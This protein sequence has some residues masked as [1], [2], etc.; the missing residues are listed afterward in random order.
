[1]TGEI[2]IQGHEL[3]IKNFKLKSMV[4]NP[5]IIMI[6]KRGSGKSW[7]IRSILKHLNRTGVPGG[8]II[9][10]S[11][12]VNPFYSDFF[13]DL[14]IHYEYRTDIMENIL[15]RQELIKNKKKEKLKQ[16]KKIDARCFLVMDDVLHDAKS[17]VKD[18]PI[19]DVMMNGRHFDVSFLLAMQYAVGIGPELRSNFDY[20]FLLAEDFINNQK[21]LYEHYAG[22][23]PDFKSFQD[24]FKQMTSNFGA[25]VIVNRGARHSFT[26]KVFKYKADVET[27]KMI[28]CKQF[29]KF[30]KLN[31]DE[32]WEKR[33]TKKLT[34]DDFARKRK[35]T[36]EQIK[37][38]FEE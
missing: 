12:K 7:V 22:M 8:V 38:Q 37:V 30:H 10:G 36:G 25:M 3:P 24:I 32:E 16:K 14:F 13:P 18:K 35:K 28:G 2:T 1:M 26:E 21:K 19:R 29:I 6:A 11:E 20:V 27:D 23:F 33:N 9:S 31:Y 34:I 15:Y 17:W 5:S 4:D